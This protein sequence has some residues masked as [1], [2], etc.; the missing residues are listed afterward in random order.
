MAGGGAQAPNCRGCRH[1]FVTHDPR[2]PHGCRAY[3]FKSAREPAEVV[4]QNSGL[5]CQLFRA[6]QRPSGPDTDGD[7]Y[8]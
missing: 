6:R 2:S 3:G 1:F 8:L 7:R 5:P 4:F